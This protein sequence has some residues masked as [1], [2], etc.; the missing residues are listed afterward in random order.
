MFMFLLI[1]LAS[2]LEKSLPTA[3]LRLVK[4][5]LIPQ[6]QRENSGLN[7]IG[8]TQTTVSVHTSNGK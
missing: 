4:T 7:K 3:D 6:R 1:G 5:F 8:E 2:C